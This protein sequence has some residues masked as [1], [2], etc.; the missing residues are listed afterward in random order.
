MKLRQRIEV[1]GQKS[2]VG[3]Q[4]SE[5]RG[6]ASEVRGQRVE[7]RGGITKGPYL[8]KVDVQGAELD[9]LGG[10]LE[11]LNET[12][13]VILEVSMFQL[14]K[15]APQF[16]DVVVYMKNLGFVVYDIF[17]ESFRPL[18]GALGQIDMAF[19]K[20]NGRFRSNH[21]YATAQQWSKV[22]KY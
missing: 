8:I 10:A 9:V 22:A 12:E 21:Q 6:R 17:G 7:I 11:T 13:L 2:E 1:R 15:D 4:K 16:Y 3:D 19:V 18:D 14:M 20:E 5:I